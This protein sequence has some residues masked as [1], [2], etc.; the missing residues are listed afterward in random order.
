MLL[1]ARQGQMLNTSFYSL[2]GNNWEGR[3]AALNFN[4]WT[5]NNPSNEFP[6]PVQGKQIIYA[7]SLNY[8]DGSF[9]KIK[10]ISL[11]YDFAKSLIRTDAVSAFRVY[12]SAT[13]PVIWSPFKLTDPETG[14]ALS[15]A[16]YFVGINLKF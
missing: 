2:S 1:Y 12:F 13:N 5:P 4:Y 11:G 14:S 10:N 8:F 9:M 7:S 15:A 16:T 3:R 6:Q